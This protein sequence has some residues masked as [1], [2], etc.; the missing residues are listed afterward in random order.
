MTI[1][2]K[3]NGYTPLVFDVFVDGDSDDDGD[4]CVIPA[5]D[6]HEGNTQCHA[7][8]R[9]RTAIRNTLSRTQPLTGNIYPLKLRTYGFSIGQFHSDFYPT[10]NSIKTNK[11]WNRHVL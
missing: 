8:Q 7:Q 11:I 2:G 5:R 1:F 3:S 9:Q 10:Y 6:E 4:K